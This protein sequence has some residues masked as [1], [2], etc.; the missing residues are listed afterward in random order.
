MILTDK[1]HFISLCS[2]FL[3][4]LFYQPKSSG[5]LWVVMQCL[6]AQNCC[7]SAQRITAQKTNSRMYITGGPYCYFMLTVL[8]MT[9]DLSR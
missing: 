4:H 3:F 9:H 5:V 6:L 7:V 8:K 2:F 1:N